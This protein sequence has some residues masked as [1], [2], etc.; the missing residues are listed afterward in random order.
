MYRY[1]CKFL[2]RFWVGVGSMYFQKIFNPLFTIK[3]QQKRYNNL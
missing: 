2:Y 3:I 1:L